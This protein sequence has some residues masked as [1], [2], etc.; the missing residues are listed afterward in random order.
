MSLSFNHRGLLVSVLALSA[1]MAPVGCGGADDAAIDEIDPAAAENVDDTEVTFEEFVKTVYREPESGMYIVDSDIPVRTLDELKELFVENY[2]DG[3]LIV[4]QVAGADAKWADHQKVNLSYCISLNFGANYAAVRNAMLDAAEAWEQATKIHFNHIAAQDGTC[5]ASNT[6][7]VFDVR[8]VSGAPYYARAFFPNFARADRNVL[9]DSTSFSTT[10][11]LTL[12][13]I[14]RHELGHALGFRHE[15]TRPESGACFEDNSWRPLTSYD[16][17]SV[18]HY[19]YCNGTGSWALEVTQTDRNGAKALYGEIG[20]AH[21]QCVAGA[22]LSP[23]C[24]PCVAKV[25]AA[26]PYCCTNSWDS[27]CVSEVQSVCGQACPSTCAHSK[28]STGAALSGSCDPSVQQI[29][30]A[31]PYCCS[32]YWD[33]YCVNEVQTVAGESCAPTC[34]HSKCAAGTNLHAACDAC[35]GQICATDPYCCN[36]AWDAQCVSEVQSVCAQTCN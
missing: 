9:I 23:V 13:G 33:A 17:A 2:Q 5:D 7:V 34:A 1:A 27:I 19:P 11:P 22:S 15:H 3:A 20:C 29:C 4:H 26:D 12:T 14:L 10:P 6:N 30:N 16:Q 31:D 35:V 28:C 36:V 21:A 8:P 18:M 24:D 32:T 25:C